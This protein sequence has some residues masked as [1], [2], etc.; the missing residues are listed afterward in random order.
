MAFDRKFYIDYLTE[1][2]HR[3]AQEGKPHICLLASEKIGFLH[4]INARTCALCRIGGTVD[5]N[6]V[7]QIS[8]GG[9]RAHLAL[10]HE[11]FHTPGEDPVKEQQVVLDLFNRAGAMASGDAEAQ[12]AVADHLKKC[13][14][15]GR[16]SLV[17]AKQIAEAHLKDLTK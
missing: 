6:F 4:G 7:E 3:E 12:K 5:A 10:I 17:Q 11:G 9:L 8:F 16:L 1:C 2:E 14:A 13:V 15:R